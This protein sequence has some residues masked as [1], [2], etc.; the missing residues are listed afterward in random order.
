M[1]RNHDGDVSRREFL[2]PS[3]LFDELDADNDGLLSPAE[4]AASKPLAAN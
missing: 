2:G 4:A 1:D 3:G